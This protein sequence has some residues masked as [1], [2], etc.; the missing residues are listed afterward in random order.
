MYF[1][2]NK[3]KK[4]FTLRPPNMIIL[5]N[6]QQLVDYAKVDKTNEGVVFTHLDFEHMRSQL[7]RSC[8]FV[9]RLK[10][11]DMNHPDFGYLQFVGRRKNH[12]IYV[13]QSHG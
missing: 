12:N 10:E 3:P 5:Q 6:Y 9:I 13:M 11:K 8:V 1:R 4:R 2:E 7:S